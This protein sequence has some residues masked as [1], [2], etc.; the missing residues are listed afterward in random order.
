MPRIGIS[1]LNV[2]INLKQI[3]PEMPP[4]APIRNHYNYPRSAS[5]QAQSIQTNQ[6]QL[7]KEKPEDD[8]RN[9]KVK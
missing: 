8:G 9:L 3:E 6:I 7:M 5:L 2:K 1:Q 4:L